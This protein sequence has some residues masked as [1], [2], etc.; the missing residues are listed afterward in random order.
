MTMASHISM[1]LRL[2]QD[3]IRHLGTVDNK[4]SLETGSID[5]YNDIV[6][7]VKVHQRLIRWEY[8]HNHYITHAEISYVEVN[9]Y[10]N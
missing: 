10:I 9:F 4:D 8:N 5:C 7:I 6:E 2:L 3:Q 1:L